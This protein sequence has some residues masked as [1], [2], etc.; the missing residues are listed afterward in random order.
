MPVLEQST[1]VAPWW[2]GN[3]HVQTLVSALTAHAPHVAYVRER[4]E[5]LD[6]DFLDLDWSAAS[7]DRLVILSYGME[8][9]ARAS[10]VRRVVLAVNRAG[11]DALVWNYRSC[12]GEPNR[13]KHFYHGGLT[14]DLHAVVR[15]ALARGYTHIDLVGFSLGGNLT[16]NYLGFRGTD[17][18][19]EIRA[20]V[21]ISTPV[22]VA[23]CARALHRPFS[24]LYAKLFLRAF[25]KRIRTKMIA[26]PGSITD[27]GYEQIHSL[28]EYDARYTV[29]DFGLETVDNFYHFVSSKHLL[30]NVRVPSLL[31]SAKNDPFMGPSCYPI[32]LARENPHLTLEMPDSGGHL[33]FI[34]RDHWLEKRVVEFLTSTPS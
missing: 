5:T 20:A 25:R 12:G 18:P 19:K 33:G 22:D 27:E 15:T 31:I 7:R 17:V 14:G 24:S 23:D 32:E 9:E 34:S 16:L 6:G 26:R 10:Y 30:H 13:K 29:P 21:A 4:I 8:S 11:W 1:Y 28:E 2:A 3:G